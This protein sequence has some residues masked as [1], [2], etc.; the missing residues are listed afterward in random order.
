MTPHDLKLPEF[1]H[2]LFA[3]QD[4]VKNLLVYYNNH[5][6]YKENHEK[7]KTWLQ[8]TKRQLQ[9]IHRTAGSKEDLG[10]KLDNMAVSDDCF[11]TNFRKF[12]IQK[13]FIYTMAFSVTHRTS[14][15][16]LV[17]SELTL[18]AV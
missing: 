6:H 4:I 3:L 7:F 2:S 16:P 1:Y 5:L 13:S 9:A 10:S 8:E 12:Q 17:K 18:H 11:F 15:I 14:Q